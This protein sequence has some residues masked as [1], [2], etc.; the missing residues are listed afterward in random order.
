MN[1]TFKMYSYILC[2]AHKVLYIK[3]YYHRLN[4]TLCI[5]FL[6]AETSSPVTRSMAKKSSTAQHTRSSDRSSNQGEADDDPKPKVKQEK[7]VHL[8]N[9][10]QSTSRALEYT[11]DEGPNTQDFECMVIMEKNIF[12][13]KE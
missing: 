4:V 6:T 11:D 10:S 2:V 5:V 12:L 9:I 13:K 1:M 7:D 8:W 3:Q